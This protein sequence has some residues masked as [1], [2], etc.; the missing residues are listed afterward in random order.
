VDEHVL[1]DLTA[2]DLKDLGVVQ[3]GDRRK[4]HPLPPRPSFTPRK[5]SRRRSANS[6]QYRSVI[7]WDRPRCRSASIPRTCAR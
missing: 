4:L 7:W 1:P 5:R 2:E 3:V 6:S